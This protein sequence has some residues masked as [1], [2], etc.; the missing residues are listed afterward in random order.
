MGEVVCFL[1]ERDKRRLSKL[2]HQNLQA[3]R[4]RHQ[5]EWICP[6]FRAEARGTAGQQGACFSFPGAEAM[7]LAVVQFVRQRD[8]KQMAAISDTCRAEVFTVLIGNAV[9][10]DF[11]IT[12]NLHGQAV[13]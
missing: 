9:T 6:L 2:L 8:A 10:D 3:L 12:D 1:R 5:I 13:A 11:A 4:P 7:H